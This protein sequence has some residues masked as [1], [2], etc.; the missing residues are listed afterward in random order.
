MTEFEI[1]EYIIKE[2]ETLGYSTIVLPLDRPYT[3][4][5][6]KFVTYPE[7]T[8]PFGIAH[9]LI[10]VKYKD[11]CRQS[12]CDTTCSYEKR[13]NKEAILYLWELFESTGGTLSNFS[14]FISVTGCPEKLAKIVILK[15]KTTNWSRE[16]VQSQVYKY[17]TKTDLEPENWNLY[18]I[19]AICNIDHKWEHLVKKIIKEYY[20]INYQPDKVG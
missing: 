11:E 16:E 1:I 13:A 19:M 20:F 15:S 7:Q 3:N 10:H 14:I 2:I 12:L 18:E 6:R 8:R 5:K 17:L 4:V 9:E